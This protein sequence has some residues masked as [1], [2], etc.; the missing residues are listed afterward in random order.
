MALSVWWK[1][2]GLV[3]AICAAGL[4]D[5]VTVRAAG[6]SSAGTER[7]TKGRPTVVLDR[8]VLPAGLPH[9]DVYERHLRQVL[10]REARR[11]DW[12]AGKGNRIEYRFFV[13]KLQLETQKGV[14]HVEC[15]ALG[16]LPKGK[17]ARSRLR[18][19]GDPQKPREVVF[20]VLEIVARG[21]ITRLSQLERARREA[22]R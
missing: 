13:D 12:G 16:R 6:Q 8:L 21:V 7:S 20:R 15:S 2:A 9:A 18:Y 3:A 17:A 4:V 11:A 14:L 5:P 1:R 10:R 22:A 19:G